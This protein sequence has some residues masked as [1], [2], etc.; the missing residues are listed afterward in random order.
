MLEW[1]EAIKP[2]IQLITY[3][4]Y[5]NAVKKRIVPYFLQK[6]I[7]LQELKPH[8]IQ[9]FYSYCLNVLKVKA[10]TVLHYHAN[11]RSALQHAFVTERISSNPADK[12]I[13]PKKAHFLGSAYTAVEVNQ[14]LEIVKGTK[15]ELAVILGAFYGLRRSE[16]IGLKWAA[17]DLVNRT[18]TIKHTVTTGSLD[19]TLITIESDE[20]KND[21]SRRTL[22]LSMPSMT[23]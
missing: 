1:L 21:P 11:I 22:L 20:T 16:V 19:G 23:F 12:V 8:H 14:L 2:S 7:L 4:S 6:G 10:N 15:S 17:I 18:I 5:T 9:D 3:I 13:R